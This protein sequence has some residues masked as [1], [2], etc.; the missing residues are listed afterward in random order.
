[1]GHPTLVLNNVNNNNNTFFVREVRIHNNN[2][3]DCV[4][5]L[6]QLQ[7]RLST[8]MITQRSINALAFN[9]GRFSLFNNV[10]IP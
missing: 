8:I 7:C 10:R 1:M 9:N 2:K 5:A 4:R 6:R 3:R